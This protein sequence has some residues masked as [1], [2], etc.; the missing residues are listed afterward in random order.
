M[1]NEKKLAC[2]RCGGEMG[3]VKTEHIQLG[4]IGGIIGTLD[5]MLAGAMLVDIYCCRDCR[6]LEFFRQDAD[7]F[8]EQTTP[9]RK[10]PNCGREHD[11][12]YPKCP[13]CSY[14]YYGK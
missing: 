2:L 6:R 8:D 10:C 11:F 3:F 1:D 5:N 12:D 14:D 13:F 7:E 4:K 9:Q